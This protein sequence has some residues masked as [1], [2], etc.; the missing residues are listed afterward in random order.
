M[1]PYPGLAQRFLPD[2]VPRRPSA[3]RMPGAIV[4]NREA[5][6][7]HNAGAEN[8]VTVERG[9]VDLAATMAEKSARMFEGGKNMVTVYQI[10]Q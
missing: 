6:A 4:S 8:L 10:P 3:L 2:R 5:T 7:N 1:L 9:P